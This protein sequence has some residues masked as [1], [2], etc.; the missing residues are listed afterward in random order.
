MFVQG[1]WFFFLCDYLFQVLKGWQFCLI[2]GVWPFAH[3]YT[4]LP[5]DCRSLGLHA[6]S[7]FWWMDGW[8]DAFRAFSLLLTYLNKS[9]EHTEHKTGCRRRSKESCEQTWR[10]VERAMRSG[11]EGDC[12][13]GSGN[14]WQLARKW[15]WFNAA[16]RWMT[17]DKQMLRGE[18]QVSTG[19][20]S[21]AG[22]VNEGKRE[23]SGAKPKSIRIHL[24]WV[25]EKE[26]LLWFIWLLPKSAAYYKFK[27]ICSQSRYRM[28]RNEKGH[29]IIFFK[30]C[31]SLLELKLSEKCKSQLKN[32]TVCLKSYFFSAVSVSPLLT[33][34]ALLIVLVRFI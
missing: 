30:F 19:G 13:K 4:L 20:R 21:S 25:S 29:G 3:T 12:Q 26:H 5:A 1:Y 17:Q 23:R 28:V 18:E 6:G 7:P 34:H 11:M 14:E 31:C 22:K 15:F 9:S 32:A 27:L 24:K 2:G 8:V 10:S 16:W 33:F